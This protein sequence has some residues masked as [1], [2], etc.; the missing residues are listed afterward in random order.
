MSKGERVNASL[1]AAAAVHK[2]L[3]ERDRDED[4]MSTFC[5]HR[6]DNQASLAL[7]TSLT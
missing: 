1:Q 7:L 3:E 4:A 2:Y 5:V 6:I